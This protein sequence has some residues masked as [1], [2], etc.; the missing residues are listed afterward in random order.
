M[1]CPPRGAALPLAVDMLE[2]LSPVIIAKGVPEITR[3]DSVIV[4]LAVPLVTVPLSGRLGSD[5]PSITSVGGL[6]TGPE[7][8]LN[9]VI[10][11][12][13]EELELE[14]AMAWAG[15]DTAMITPKAAIIIAI[16]LFLNFKT[17]IDHISS[18]NTL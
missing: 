10:V 16:I 14:A 9:P 7:V 8:V 5:V 11:T 13:A 18:V 4:A 3:V 1:D 15:P 17:V 6:E 12:V 2:T